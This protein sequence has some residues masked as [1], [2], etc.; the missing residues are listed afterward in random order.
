MC[1]RLALS[2]QT[3][4]SLAQRIL[5]RPAQA[6]GHGPSPAQLRPAQV[7]PVQPS[8]VQFIQLSSAHPAQHSKVHPAQFT[9]LS[10]VQPLSPSLA[11]VCLAQ[12]SPA[13]D[14]SA[15][16]ASQAHLS[17]PR[18]GQRMWPQ[19]SLLSSPVQG[20]LIAAFPL[21]LGWW[22]LCWPIHIQPTVHPVRDPCPQPRALPQ[23][24]AIRGSW[25]LVISRLAVGNLS[26]PWVP[27]QGRDS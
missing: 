8:S 3:T 12:V 1:L 6:R 2:T 5:A 11:Q 9:Q 22:P 16:L 20:Q 7:S 24:C 4:P 17:Q 25:L 26:F 15:Q 18:S 10:P 23:P 21:T 13:Q 14:S 27:I 19:A